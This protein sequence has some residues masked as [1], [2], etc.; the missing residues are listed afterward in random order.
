MIIILD[1]NVIISACLNEKSEI[2]KII[3]NL[4]VKID[5]LIPDYALEEI[6]KHKFALCKN[7][8]YSIS[9]FD[10]LLSQCCDNATIFSVED[11]STSIFQ[12]AA[13]LTS[14][15]DFNDK[16][17]VA[18]SIAFDALIWTGDFKLNRGLKRA[19]F[20]N[21]I[22]TKEFKDILKGL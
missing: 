3:S 16:A 6:T 5:F 1:T 10:K 19:G 7:T 20:K 18:F 11:I 17:F 4:S 8:G 13:E 9:Q 2:F 15:I 14:N 22:S 12:Q 21:I